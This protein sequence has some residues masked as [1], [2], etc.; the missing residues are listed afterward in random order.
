VILF[1]FFNNPSISFVAQKSWLTW[2][3][4]H[5]LYLHSEKTKNSLK[6]V[7]FN[8]LCF[9]IHVY[10]KQKQWWPPGDRSKKE[11]HATKIYQ[12][13]IINSCNSPH[14]SHSQI[15]VHAVTFIYVRE[16]SPLSQVQINDIKVG[17][18][19]IRDI[20]TQSAFVRSTIGW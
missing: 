11:N 6:L 2:H 16:G 5:L 9:K 12:R 10:C 7:C 20:A 13:V 19:V 17:M 4:W 8:E 15:W 3:I 14:F 18:A 1:F